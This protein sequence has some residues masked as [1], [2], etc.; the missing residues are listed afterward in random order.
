REMTARTAGRG[1]C[2]MGGVEAPYAPNA[3]IG[4]GAASLPNPRSS[5]DRPRGDALVR[6]LCFSVSALAVI[7]ATPRA[8]HAQA[9]QP[10][11]SPLPPVQIDAPSQKPR[12]KAAPTTKQG[13]KTAARAPRRNPQPAAAPPAPAAAPTAR[14]ETQDQRSGTAGVYANNTPVATK[15]N[16]PV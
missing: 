8:R 6:L 14:S 1:G 2:G 12:R 7:V 13:P 4:I 10:P 16:T 11:A 9:A 3:D 15:V 5:K